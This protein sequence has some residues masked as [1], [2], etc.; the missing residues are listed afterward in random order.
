MS[1]LFSNT[2][3]TQASFSSPMK[4][5]VPSHPGLKIM[6]GWLDVG[7]GMK[8][9]EKERRGQRGRGKC[10]EDQLTDHSIAALLY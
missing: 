2:P 7:G 9:K 1:P 5:N 3:G 4:W 8:S 10:S 6:Y